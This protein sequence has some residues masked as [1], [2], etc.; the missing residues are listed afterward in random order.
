MRRLE[1]CTTRSVAFLFLAL[2]DLVLGGLG[3]GDVGE[4]EGLPGVLGWLGGDEP[5][6][7]AG[8]AV[9]E[10]G[11]G[12][13]EL[14]GKGDHA[15]EAVVGAEVEPGLVE[16]AGAAGGVAESVDVNGDPGELL[17]GLVVERELDPG[18]EAL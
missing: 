1:A 11:G 4:G 15:V 18:A 3:G 2:A 6:P 7:E 8:R 10:D 17:G 12:R 14:E 5:A 13:V 16:V 9:G